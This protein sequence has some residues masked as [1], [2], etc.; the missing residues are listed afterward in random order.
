MFSFENVL[1]HTERKAFL[2][3]NVVF[4]C[5]RINVDIASENYLI[6]FEQ[7]GISN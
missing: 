4:K 5:I 7:H 6:H 2:S 3:E 1:I